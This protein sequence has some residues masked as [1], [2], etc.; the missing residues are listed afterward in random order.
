MDNKIKGNIQ[1]I[2]DKARKDNKVSAVA[3]FGSYARGE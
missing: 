2:I 3:L 1:K